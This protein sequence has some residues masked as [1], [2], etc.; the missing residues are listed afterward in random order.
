MLLTENYQKLV[1]ACQNYSLSKFFLRHSVLKYKNEHLQIAWSCSRVDTGSTVL[2]GCVR[3]PCRQ[4]TLIS[5]NII[6]S[7]QLLAT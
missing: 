7:L 5:I 6:S 3:P 2:S 4:T 1:H